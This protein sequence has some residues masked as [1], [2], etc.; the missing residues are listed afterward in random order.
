MVTF[1]PLI[2][3]VISGRFST[4]EL[5]DLNSEYQL[6]LGGF[7]LV[8]KKG[9]VSIYDKLQQKYQYFFVKVIV[10]RC[11]ILKGLDN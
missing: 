1:I 9:I 10:L 7:I 11:F 5:L 2:C 8:L 6:I 4:E 3:R